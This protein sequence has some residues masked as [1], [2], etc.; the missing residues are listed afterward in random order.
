MILG[1][2]AATAACLSL[3]KQIAVQDLAYDDLKARLLAD[4]QVL[5][6]DS[7][8][9]GYTPLDSLEGTVI[10]DTQATLEG[11]W[12]KSGVAAGVHQGYLHDGDLRDGTCRATFPAELEAGTYEIQIAY[13]PN[14][15]RA[16]NVPVTL[17]S[18]GEAVR[19]TL[20]QRK[21]PDAGAFHRLGERD[22]TGPTAL[23]ITN[24]STDGHVIVDAVRFQRMQLR[25]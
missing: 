9:G 15:N 13:V 8:L 11:P 2:S 24:E 25:D 23:V 12:E 20:N 17:A 18:A 6:F 3:D 21:T 16:T 1:Q 5:E 10:D 14:P 4:Q 7:P 22:L 19:F